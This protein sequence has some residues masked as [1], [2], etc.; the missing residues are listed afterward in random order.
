MKAVILAAGR[1]TRI[2]PVTRGLPKCLLVFGGR[3]ILDW[4]I[5]GLR[6]VGISDIAIVIGHNGRWIVEHVKS[7][8]REQSDG[9]H[10]IVNP[11]FEITNNIYSLWLAK[12]WVRG[13]GFICLNAD[14]L[15]HPSILLPAVLTPGPVSM[16]VDPEWRDETMKV[17]IRNG[18]VTRMGK[19]ISREDY[20]ATYIGITA[21]SRTIVPALFRE[22]QG[23]IEAGNVN[24]FF[25]I[26]VQR[27]IEKG[28]RVGVSATGN[29][30]WAEID[31]PGDLRFAREEIFP[32]MAKHL[33]RAA[34]AVSLQKFTVG[35][36]QGISAAARQVPDPRRHVTNNCQVTT[37]NADEASA[38]PV[39]L[40]LCSR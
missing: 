11:E 4:Q 39:G 18:Y 1:G 16:I 38:K 5:E 8:H 36:G 31:D 12:D 23:F 14:V 30:P 24:E 10:F 29:L 33:K 19:A 20:S 26:A 9:I 32:R 6:S 21:F 22:I 37:A 7:F 25:N 40:C 35:G 15:C 27:L 28:V 34:Q 3:T 13:S 2:E 17:V